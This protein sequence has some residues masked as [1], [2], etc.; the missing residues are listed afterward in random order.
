[1][2][3]I[4]AYLQQGLEPLCRRAGYGVTFKLNAHDFLHEMSGNRLALPPEFME[5]NEVGKSNSSAPGGLCLRER[6]G[7]RTPWL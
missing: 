5:K 7:G 4:A 6:Q 1:M 3:F 2:T